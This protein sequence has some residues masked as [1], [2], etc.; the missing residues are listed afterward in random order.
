MITPGLGSAGIAGEPPA[1]SIDPNADAVFTLVSPSTH[2][3]SVSRSCRLRGV[4][5]QWTGSA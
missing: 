1:T 4:D 2:G 5:S 3:K